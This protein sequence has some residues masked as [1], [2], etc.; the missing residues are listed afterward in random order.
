ME[1]GYRFAIV[2]AIASD[3]AAIVTLTLFM[4]LARGD[5]RNR[6][7]GSGQPRSDVPPTP[8]GIDRSPV[9]PVGEM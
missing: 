9:A 5:T 8:P 1:H 7:T 4:I 6:R 2:L 3:L